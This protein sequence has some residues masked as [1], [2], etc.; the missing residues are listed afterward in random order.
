MP[1]IGQVEGMR[2]AEEDI[3]AI[4]W[5]ASSDAEEQGGSYTGK[6][7]SGWLLGEGDDGGEGT[8]ESGWARW[9]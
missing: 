9:G 4:S 7:E 5:Q 8:Q 6:T 3:P 1:M 2:Q